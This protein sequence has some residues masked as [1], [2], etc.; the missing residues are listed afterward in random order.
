M[1]RL[2]LLSVLFFLAL[3]AMAQLEIKPGSFVEVLGFVNINDKQYDDNGTPYAVIKV[4]TENINDKE[5]QGTPQ[6]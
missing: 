1:K 6:T 3:G 5:R 4:R 2:V